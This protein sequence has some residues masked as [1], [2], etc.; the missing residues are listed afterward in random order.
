MDAAGLAPR[1]TLLARAYLRTADPA[2]SGLGPAGA[3]IAARQLG[4]TDFLARRLIESTAG[5]RRAGCL[6]PAG[7]AQW[8]WRMGSGRTPSQQPAG[9]GAGHTGPAPGQ[10]R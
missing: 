10:R 5:E 7:S 6:C 4:N 8:R 1:D 3:W 9:H 2:H